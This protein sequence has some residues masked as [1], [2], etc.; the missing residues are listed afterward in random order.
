MCVR[1]ASPA[2]GCAVRG[3]AGIIEV[4]CL[5]GTSFNG[6]TPRSGRGYWGS[7]PYVPATIFQRFESTALTSILLIRLSSGVAAPEVAFNCAAPI[8]CQRLPSPGVVNREFESEV[9]LTHVT[10]ATQLDAEPDFRLA[11]SARP[12]RRVRRGDAFRNGFDV[13]AIVEC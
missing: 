10:S 13:R 12:P 11:A 9:G 7:N 4:S 3:S 1:R 5:L 8:S 2:Q 6:R